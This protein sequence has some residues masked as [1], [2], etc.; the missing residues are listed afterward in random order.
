MIRL[1]GYNIGKFQKL[2][3][4]IL[5]LYFKC[6]KMKTSY[7]DELNVWKFME[8]YNVKYQLTNQD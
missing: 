6:A 1:E 3:K 7:T 8:G 4:Y 5:E 2:W